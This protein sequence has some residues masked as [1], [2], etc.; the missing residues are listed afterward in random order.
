[1]VL[2]PRSMLI[3]SA[4]QYNFADNLPWRFRS[5]PDADFRE[6]CPYFSCLGNTGYE[7]RRLCIAAC[8]PL[9]GIN[10][11]ERLQ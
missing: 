10:G 5:W 8:V 7:S 3:W 6:S 2:W 1:M 9:A 11:D 4:Q